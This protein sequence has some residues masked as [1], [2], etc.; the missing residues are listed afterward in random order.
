MKA[1]IRPLLLGDEKTWLEMRSQLWPE[2][3][4]AELQEDQLRIQSAPSRNAVFVAENSAGIPI[5]FVEVS[6]SDWAEGCRTEPV[7]YLEGW[8]VLTEYRQQGIGKEL[9]EAAENWAI[10]KGCSEMASDTERQNQLSRDAHKAL[11]YR[12]VAEVVSFGKP[13]K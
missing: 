12:E 13:L 3:T 4:M 9:V 7:G 10:A 5:G 11:G 2:Y 6:I 1:H 8:Y